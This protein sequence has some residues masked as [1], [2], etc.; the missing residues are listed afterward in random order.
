MILKDLNSIRKKSQASIMGAVAAFVP[1]N[2]FL[3][4]I[5]EMMKFWLLDLEEKA[6]LS[7]ISQVSDSKSIKL[8]SLTQS[9]F[10]A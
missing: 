4:F 2:A 7:L 8:R 9:A 10:L 1:N 5:D 3:N 6:T